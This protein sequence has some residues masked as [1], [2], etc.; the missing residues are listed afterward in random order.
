M[1]KASIY[2]S[3]KQIT[4]LTSTCVGRTDGRS[5][6]WVRFVV[7]GEEQEGRVRWVKVRLEKETKGR[8]KQY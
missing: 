6:E 2:R 5:V 7:H 8:G 3:T 4:H 1:F